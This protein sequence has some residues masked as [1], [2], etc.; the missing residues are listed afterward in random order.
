MTSYKFPKLYKKLVSLVCWQFTAKMLN[1][2][3]YAVLRPS[4]S[5]YMEEDKCKTIT[6]VPYF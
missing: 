2:L 5:E 4:K 6:T 3:K 1:V